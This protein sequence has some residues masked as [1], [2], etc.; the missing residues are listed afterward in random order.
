MHTKNSISIVIPAYNEG[1]G[2][3]AF[4]D[5]LEAHLDHINQ[6]SFNYIIVN[7]GSSDDTPSHL[8]NYSFKRPARIIHLSRNFGKES[9]ITAGLAHVDGQACIIMDADFQHP[10]PIINTLL[11]T[12][13]NN[14]FDMVYTVRENRNDEGLL[15]RLFTKC[16][17]AIVNRG[18]NPN[19]PK[20]AGD[21]RLLNRKVIDALLLCQERVRFMKGLY[22]WV[23][24][25]TKAITFTVD[26]RQ[27]GNSKWHFIKLV[28]YAIQAIIS[29][30]D[31]PLQMWTVI[32]FL[33]ATASF[34]YGAYNIII[35]LTH[36]VHVPGYPTLVTAIFFFGGI[37]LISIG[38]I[39]E[40]L[41][42]VF[43]EV[44]GRPTYLIRDMYD[45]T[46]N[47]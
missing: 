36:H 39:G 17:Y 29:F 42:R 14:E 26:E 30:T 27:H 46:P 24:F 34:L 13:N 18:R 31:F 12:W 5:A 6:Y 9:A 33:I 37:Q 44:K 43:Q 8:N 1:S 11:E 7:D 16:F 28:R 3:T 47:D 23:G 45:N 25:K 2:L 41:A 4:L 32:G 15:K 35:A 20:D 19:L 22:A 21:F 10:L 38:V 40:Y